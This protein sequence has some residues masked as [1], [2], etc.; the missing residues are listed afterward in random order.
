MSEIVDTSVFD[1]AIAEMRRRSKLKL[2]Q[3]DFDAWAWD[4]L[5]LRNYKK[6]R[7]IINDS[8]FAAKSRTLTKSGNGVGKSAS[9]A[10]AIL[11]AGSVFPEGDTV[12]IISA[13][14]I[15]QLQK[16]T[17]AYLKSYHGRVNAEL[18][19]E[20]FQIPGR[21]DENL[22]W[23]SETPNGKIWLASGRKPPDQDAVS[24]F[25]G[26]RSQTGMTYV[27]FDEAG[28][29]SKAMFTAAEAVQTGDDSRFGGIGNPDNAG[30]E[31]QASFEDPE[32]AAEYNLHTISVFDTPVFTGER[33][34]PRTQEGD[35]M[36]A[37]LLRA[38]TSKR[39]VAHKSRIWATGGEIIEDPKHIG[40]PRYNTRVDKTVPFIKGEIE[41][42]GKETIERDGKQLVLLEKIKWDARG[43]SKV[44][45]EFPGENDT[46][47][48]STAIITA[49]RARDIPEDLAVRPV[50]G[51]DI[52]RF[53][54]DESVIFSNR[55]GRARLLD[56]WGKSSTVES[57]RRIHRQAQDSSA[58]EVRI[59]ASGVGGGVYDMLRELE[60]FHDK[61]YILIGIDGGKRSS[62]PRRWANARAENHDSLRTLMTGEGDYSRIDLDYDDKELRDQLTNVTYRYSKASNAIQITPKD[63]MRTEMGGSPDRLDALIY[64]ALDVSALF[65][66]KSPYEVGDIILQDPWEMQTNSWW[67]GENYFL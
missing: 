28:G 42:I 22:G 35:Q 47:F 56:T 38:L 34:Y 40:D 36:E 21:I 41:H 52:A 57:A 51:V 14:S 1:S 53:G 7:E 8:L 49:A 48:F 27:W 63:E 19:P 5:K 62:D 66:E 30:A 26:L 33:V 46:A 25:Q 55:G 60:E 61:R 58:A 16:V 3:T 59:D 50:F 45:G 65:A 37:Q 18:R 2:Y 9:M 31:W 15:P 43:L 54:S 32:K 4:I 24:M 12:Q 67:A 44:L 10:Q 17:F 6:I 20:H 11:W 64:A 13:P 39:W 29:M 23:V